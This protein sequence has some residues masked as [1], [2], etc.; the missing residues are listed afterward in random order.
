MRTRPSDDLRTARRIIALALGLA[1]DRV[2][3]IQRIIE[4]APACVGRVQGKACIHHRNNQLRSGDG[5]DFR[6]N[7]LGIHGERRGLIHE[8]ANL[9]Q[10][11]LIFSCIDRLA[12][13]LFVPSINLLLQIIAL[14]QKCGVLGHQV[15]QHLR[16][17]RP[18]H[19]GGHVQQHLLFDQCGQRCGHLQTLALNIIGHGVLHF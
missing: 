19:V 12:L 17:A 16:I 3:A 18:E 13:T 2:G 14:G 9:F 8:I 10:E 4:R 6:V 11:R 5:C 1:F 15:M 7:V